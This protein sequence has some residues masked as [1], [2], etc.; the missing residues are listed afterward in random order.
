MVRRELP[1]G[2]QH[3]HLQWNPVQHETPKRDETFVSRKVTRAATRIKL[4]LQGKPDG[5]PRKLL[6]SSRLRGLG[7]EA[8]IPL[9]AGLEETYRWFR[10]SPTPAA[11]A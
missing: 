8:S 11:H 4:G 5:M 9:K 1:G 10:E 7:W 3:L 6:D 2:V